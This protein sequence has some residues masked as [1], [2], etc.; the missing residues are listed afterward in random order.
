MKL[1]SAVVGIA[2]FVTF[3]CITAATPA[4]VKVFTVRAGATVLDKIRPE[5]ERATGHRL[6]VV[7]DPAL[8]SY[9]RRIN[10]GEPFDVYIA[11]PP[12][13][14]GLIKDGKIVAETRTNLF[15]SGMGVEVRAGASRPDISSVEAF[16]RALLNAKS[17]GY[18]TPNRVDVLIDRLGLTDAVRTKVTAPNSDVVSE[19]VANGELEL[20]IVVTTQVLTTS[21]VE[22]VGPLPPEIQYDFQFTA[23]VSV[24]SKAP[25]AARDLIKFL[26]GPFAIPVIKSQG[27]EPG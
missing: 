27:M 15:H 8:G 9:A 5:F 3:G 18:I 11:A 23:G 17:I 13:I 26:T 2:L 14:D 25:D 1:R 24:N 6:D 21:G 10:A 7:Y 4:E 12:G 20:G 22:L 19:L 16:K